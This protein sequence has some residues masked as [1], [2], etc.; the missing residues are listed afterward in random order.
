LWDSPERPRACTLHV[1]EG[2]YELAVTTEGSPGTLT[3]RTALVTGAANG[4]GRAIAEAACAAGAR[5]ILGDVARDDLAKLARQLSARGAEVVAQECDVRRL[6]QIESLVAEGAR[7]FAAPD[8]VFA[9]AGIEGPFGAPWDCTDGEF[10]GVLDVNVAGIW[11]TLRVTLPHMV[12]RRSGAIV[13]TASA[14]GLVGAGGLAAY[15]ASKHAVV[16]LIR[17]VAASVAKS[18]VRVNALCP[19]MVGTALL[20]RLTK[21]EPAIHEALL[22]QT[23]MGRLGRLDEIAAAAIWLASNEASYMTGATLAVDGGYTSQ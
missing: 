13:A 9:N 23:P 11:R 19:G 3:G 5:L 2:V 12:E 10:M 21:I 17:S 22:S 6:E 16:G 8:V 20:D 14:A 4:I 7:R 18:G 1:N 15:V